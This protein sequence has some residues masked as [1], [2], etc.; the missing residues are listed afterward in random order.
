MMPLDRLTALGTSVW[1]DGLVPHAELEHLALAGVTGMTTNGS[2]TDAAN[3]L[4]PWARARASAID[5]RR[6]L[7]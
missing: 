3:L 5:R 6:G 1:I 7:V 2:F 4:R